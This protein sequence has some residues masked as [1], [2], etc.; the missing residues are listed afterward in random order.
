[1]ES[2]TF[3]KNAAVLHGGAVY[4]RYVSLFTE[5]LPVSAFRN[6]TFHGNSAVSGGA[7]GVYRLQVWCYKRSMRTKTPPAPP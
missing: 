5:V 4:L 6:L 3:S 7:V 2:N 1:M